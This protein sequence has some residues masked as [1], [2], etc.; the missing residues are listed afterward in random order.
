MGRLSKACQAHHGNLSKNTKAHVDDCSDGDDDDYR[1]PSEKEDEDIPP[2]EVLLFL[3]KDDLES[4]LELKDEEEDL[5]IKEIKRE[6]AILRFSAVL[7]EAQAMAVK[8]KWE[9]ES[10]QKWGLYKKNSART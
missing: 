3:D 1:P 5:M 9:L 6:A 8:A 7:T 10:K 2:H 4:D